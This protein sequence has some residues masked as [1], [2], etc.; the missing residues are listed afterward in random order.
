[1]FILFLFIIFVIGVVLI[2]K[3]GDYIVEVCGKLSDVTGIHETLIGSTLTSVATTLPEL[4]I[5][6]LA[7]TQNSQQIV[8]GNGLGTILVNICLVLGLSLSVMSLKRFNKTTINKLI[9]LTI[10]QSIL[11]ILLIFKLLNIYTG[12]ILL[13][14]FCVYFIKTFFDIK[15]NLLNK[16]KINIDNPTEK[17][18]ENNID[19]IL[20][21]L[22]FIVG[23]LFIFAG[24]QFII[25]ATEDLSVKL[26]ISQTLI[27]LILISISTSLP[28]LV[29]TITSIKK[30]RLNLA[31]GNVIGANIINC[32]LLFGL[33]GVLSGKN[34]LILSTRE[35]A[36]ILP[37]ILL[38]SLLLAFPILFKKRTYKWQGYMLISLYVIYTF[39]IILYG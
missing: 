33:S 5:T 22:K 39:V 35:I 34:S 29:T 6:I 36:I 13:L 1:M 12:I 14:I 21:V 16:G 10:I 7:M 26:N 2:I 27:A 20:L 24:A 28:E 19:K 23:S 32:T 17:P 37:T 4:T 3:G 9:F 30:K 11:V 25:N 31:L 8:V 15:K 38:A 18:K